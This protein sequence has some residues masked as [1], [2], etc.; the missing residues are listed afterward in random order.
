MSYII[1]TKRERICL[2]MGMKLVSKATIAFL[3]SLSL[4]SS[5]EG[6]L[7]SIH[8]EQKRKR[9]QKLSLKFVIYSLIFFSFAPAFAWCEKAFRL[10]SGPLL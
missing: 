4:S 9:K 7:R 6:P 2:K 8:I 1:H 10:C 3:S 5:V